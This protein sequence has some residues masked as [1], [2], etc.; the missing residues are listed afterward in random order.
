M[1]EP[2]SSLSSGLSGAGLDLRVAGRES[3]SLALVDARNT[4]LHRLRQLEEGLDAAG[5]DVRRGRGFDAPLWLAGHLGWFQEWWIGRNPQRARG[6]QAPAD[7][8]RLAS[9]DPRADALWNPE[10]AAA[11]TV[12]DAELPTPAEVRAWLLDTLESTLELLDKSAEDDD[13]LY[14]YRLALFHEDQC[15]ER[16]ARIADACGVAMDVDAPPG[17]LGSVRTVGVPATRW[18]LGTRRG[19]GCGFAW[20]NEGPAHEVALPGFEIDAQPVSWSQFAEFV[21]DGG[22]DNPGWWGA[23]GWAWLQAQ[24]AQGGRRAPRQVEQ[25]GSASGAV[26]QTRFG[27]ARRLRGTQS[28]VHASGWEAQAWCNWAG[29]RLPTEAEWEVAA[30]S[31]RARGFQWGDVHEWTAST[32]RPYPGFRAGP[33]ASYSLPWFERAWALRGASFAT[34]GRLRHP[35]ARGFALPDDDSGF[36]GFRSCAP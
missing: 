17:A 18:T 33:W 11:D 21:D 34:H 2:S 25:I 6:E 7:G 29:R 16:L 5:V 14:F 10:L 3:L 22:Y 32:F 8:L 20:D 24:A 4:T 15:G 23:A 13:A 26:I 27:Q 1:A 12:G 30:C 31:M 19:P 35:R 36:T 28:V 9:V